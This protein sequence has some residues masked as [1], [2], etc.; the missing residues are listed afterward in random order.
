MGGST[1]PQA[2]YPG[3]LLQPLFSSWLRFLVRLLVAVVSVFGSARLGSEPCQ[4]TVGKRAGKRAA[5]STHGWEACLVNSRLGSMPWQLPVGKPCP[6]PVGKRSCQLTVFSCSP[7]CTRRVARAVL[8]APCCT[9]R[10]LRC[11]HHRTSSAMKKRK[12]RWLLPTNFRAPAFL[13]LFG[14][15]HMTD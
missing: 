5:L 12:S 11:R 3:S 6:L 14:N 10:L 7:C 2:I 13:S 8:H 1:A 4:L 9:P 15:L